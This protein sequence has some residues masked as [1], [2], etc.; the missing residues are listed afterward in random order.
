[1]EDFDPDTDFNFFYLPDPNRSTKPLVTTLDIDGRKVTMEIDTGAG[2]TIFSEKEWRNHGSP[3]LEDTQVAT[4]IHR[5][6]SGHKRKIR[7]N[8]IST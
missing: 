6:T 3:K 7:G 8:S 2:F 5:P 1:M 4:D